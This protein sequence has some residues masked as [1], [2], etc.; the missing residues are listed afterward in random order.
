MKPKNVLI[1]SSCIN[2]SSVSLKWAGFGYPLSVD[3]N[4]SYSTKIVKGSTKWM[5]PELLTFLSQSYGT[6]TASVY[7]DVFSAGLLFFS[8]VA[9]GIHPFGDEDN[10]MEIPFNIAEFNCVNSKSK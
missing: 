8:Y 10:P 4:G 3:V 5:A 2:T 6:I 7:G 9:G 1:A